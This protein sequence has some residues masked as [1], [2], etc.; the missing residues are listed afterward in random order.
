MGQGQVIGFYRLHGAPWALMLHAEGRQIM[1]PIRR[2]HFYYLGGGALC[3]GIILLLI[4]LGVH[5]LV[6]NIR[7]IS[8]RAAQV[9][10]GEYGEPLP[11][12]TRDEIG[13]LTDSFNDMVRG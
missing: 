6:S 8:Q 13:Q 10:A 2:F 12:K 4:R 1:A 11:V 7:V 9:A 5:P 3:L